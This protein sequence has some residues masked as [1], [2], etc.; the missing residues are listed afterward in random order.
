MHSH[1]VPTTILL[2]SQGTCAGGYL[3]GSANCC[4][5]QMAGYCGGQ[6]GCFE[7][8]YG[9]GLVSMGSAEP[10]DRGHGL[11]TVEFS[12]EGLKTLGLDPAQWGGNTS[13]LYYQG[14]VQVRIGTQL[15]LCCGAC[16]SMVSSLFSSV[17]PLEPSP[18]DVLLRLAWPC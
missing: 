14:P 16:V 1:K 17:L 2:T 10:W 7:S 9:L 15:I 3:A 11:V 13:I 6:V 12:T 4:E 5:E 18:S 8:S